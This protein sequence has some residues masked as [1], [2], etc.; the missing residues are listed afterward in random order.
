MSGLLVRS[1]RVAELLPDDVAYE[2]AMSVLPDWRRRKCESFRFPDDRRRSVAAWLLLRPLLVERGIDADV[3]AVRENEFGKPEFVDLPDVRFSI[4]HSG[5]RVMAAVSDSPVGCDVEK[6]APIR[7]DVVEA[8]LT[9]DELDFLK[10]LPEGLE[11]DREFCRL[12]VRKESYVKAC[13]RGLSMEPKS[14]SVLPGKMTGDFRDFDFG[15]GYL[16]CAC[17]L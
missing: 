8:C 4:S 9:S 6:L 15:D 7:D 13:G 10:T 1:V 11:R 12:W 2:R 5:E 17:V 3:Q 14:F 16:G